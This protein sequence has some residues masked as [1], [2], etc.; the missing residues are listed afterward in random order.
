[1]KKRQKISRVLVA[2]VISIMLLFGVVSI[3]LTP[4]TARTNV[5]LIRIQ[6]PILSGKN[7]FVPE[8]TFSD[9]IVNLIEE[10][11]KNKNIRAIIFEINSPGGSAVASKEISDAIKE[12]KK[13]K[14]TI[15]L[16]R[17]LGVSGAYWVASAC[18]YIIASPM[19]I[20]GSIGVTA[21]YLEY[22]KLLERLNITYQRLV[23]GK[24]KDIGSPYKNLTQE[25]RELL[26]NILDSVHREF[27]LEIKTNRNLTEEQTKEIAK[28]MFYLGKEAK[29]LGLIDFLGSKKDVI[30]Y[31]EEK[32]KI[33]ANIKEYQTKRG[34]GLF[35][36]VFSFFGFWFGRGAASYLLEKASA[37]NLKIFTKI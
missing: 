33:K 19:S 18:H 25:E 3:L 9:D 34:F 4:K 29:E 8:A 16:I 30:K 17:E 24:Y 35:Y 11:K 10:V 36:D 27:V 14:L 12:I 7:E 28:G 2:I 22:S 6:G 13:E 26:Q 31:I 32:E 21:S 37:E 23:A 15:A 20:T 5:A 1:M